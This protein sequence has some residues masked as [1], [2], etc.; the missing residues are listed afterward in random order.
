MVYPYLIPSTTNECHPISL[1]ALAH[2]LNP[3]VA[4]VFER[5]KW[6]GGLWS[7]GGNNILLTLSNEF[8][9]LRSITPPGR[10]KQSNV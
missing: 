8:S 10:T 9:S 5:Y 6:Y 7:G 4:I 3:E 1:S 2:S